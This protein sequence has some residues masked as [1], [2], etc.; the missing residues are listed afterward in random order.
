M[1]TQ[2]QFVHVLI[3]E[4]GHR[5]KLSTNYYENKIHKTRGTGPA[6]HVL[7][8]TKKR[9]YEKWCR[10]RDLNSRPSDYKSD[11]LPTELY[12]HLRFN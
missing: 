11:A 9:C 2:N 3:T 6:L 12:R 4:L 8:L 10:Q 7:K 5:F 1:I